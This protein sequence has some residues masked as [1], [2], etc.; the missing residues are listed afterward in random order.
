[1]SQW[2]RAW[3]QNGSS[4]VDSH[5]DWSWKNFH[6]VWTILMITIWTFHQR[7]FFYWNLMIFLNFD[8]DFHLI[9]GWELFK[10]EFLHKF[11]NNFH[12]YFQSIFDPFLSNFRNLSRLNCLKKGEFLA[13]HCTLGPIIVKF[14]LLTLIYFRPIL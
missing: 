6:R 5:H 10:Y 1:M 13:S 11:C 7:F 4:L 3:V 12:C 8:D 2:H 14:P 9:F